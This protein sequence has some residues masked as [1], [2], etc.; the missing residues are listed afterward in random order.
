[1]FQNGN[2]FFSPNSI[3]HCGTVRKLFVLIKQRIIR[4][5]NSA[6]VIRAF[7][8][9]STYRERG[10]T[11]DTVIGPWVVSRRFLKKKKKKGESFQAI[12]Q[13]EQ[14]VGQKS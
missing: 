8:G 3:C 1:M 5:S 2:W 11:R 14:N 10:P 7:F 4:A 13:D 9:Y 6:L 12:L